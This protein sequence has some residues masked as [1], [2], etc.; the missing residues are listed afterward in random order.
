MKHSVLSILMLCCSILIYSQKPPPASGRWCKFDPHY[1]SVDKGPQKAAGHK[2]FPT[3]D[4]LIDPAGVIKIPVVVHILYNTSNQNIPD[5]R[6]ISQ[7]Q[8]FNLDFRKLNPDVSNIPPVWAN[9]PEDAKF[10][11]QLACIDPQG[12]PTT[13][14]TR[15]FTSIT[16][17]V[18]NGVNCE[19]V[20]TAAAGWPPE[21]YLNIWV[22]NLDPST[23]GSSSSPG[24]YLVF[25]N[26]DGLVLDYEIVGDNNGHPT[27]NL[28]R[29]ASHEAGHWLGLY[30]TFNDGWPDCNFSDQVNDT[31]TS[32]FASQNC[33]AFPLLDNCQPLSPGV[34]FM[35]YMDYSNDPCRYMFTAGQCARMRSFIAIPGSIRYPFIDKYFGLGNAATPTATP[36]QFTVS[37][38]NPLCLPYTTS[39]TGG[40]VISTTNTSVLVET[41]AGVNCGGFTLVITSAANNYEDE[42][43]F[44]YTNIPLQVP[45]VINVT[46]LSEMCQPP[47]TQ[48]CVPM[49]N[50]NEVMTYD[51]CPGYVSYDW[52]VI[53][54]TILSGAGTNSI[55]VQHTPGW[56]PPSYHG[57]R[58]RVYDGTN[59]SPFTEVSYIGCLGCDPLLKGGQT[60]SPLRISPNPGSGIINIRL[61]NKEYIERIIIKD[62]SGN[63]LVDKFV[64]AAT[65]L[66]YDLTAFRQGVFYIQ[67]FDGK[68]WIS[69]K[70][71]KK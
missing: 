21:T 29:V 53:E 60:N 41:P 23:Y 61:G 17:F 66:T 62:I 49:W 13:G 11:F 36:R 3:K 63:N 56:P 69:G 45:L 65:E 50:G 37:V 67:V 32:E 44:S 22:A 7:L 42:G 38:S 12:I 5:S 8:R 19:D 28:G 40:T 10:E 16:E 25:P 51:V 31:P 18:C 30:H 43:V 4:V 48:P 68:K 47:N 54:G 46:G 39:I 14:I 71:L 9:L 35:N 52:Q 55:N 34:M 27:K 26:A 59:W 15:T 33:P 6:V 20:R 57:A 1:G 70:F 24:M 58:V 2:G 64:G